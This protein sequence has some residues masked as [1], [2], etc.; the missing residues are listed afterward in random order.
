MIADAPSVTGSQ[1]RDSPPELLACISPESFS[2]IPPEI[3]A[4][5]MG[6]TSEESRAC[7][8]G[9]FSA[10]GNFME[11]ALTFF[12]ERAEDLSPEDFLDIAEGGSRLFDCLTDEE[13]AG[14]QEK[15]LPTMLP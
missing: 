5:G 11:L 6:A 4:L 8:A 10:R 15:Y 2:R 7:V 14:F 13:L 3:L 1:L 12:E 9:L